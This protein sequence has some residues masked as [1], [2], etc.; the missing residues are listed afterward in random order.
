MSAWASSQMSPSRWPRSARAVATPATEPAEI[1]WSPPSTNGICPSRTNAAVRLAVSR[2]IAVIVGR[3]SMPVATPRVSRVGTETSP[4]ST[5]VC[6]IRSRCS[7]SRASRTA[8][9]PISTPRREAPKSTGTPRIAI[10]AMGYLTVSP[11]AG[12]RTRS[13]ISEGRCCRSA[14]GVPERAGNVP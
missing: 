11:G 1:E 3:K 10:D 7:A 6:P 13:R 8:E 12:A 5:T 2:Q 4:V 14:A 9:G